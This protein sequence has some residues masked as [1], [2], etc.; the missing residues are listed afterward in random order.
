MQRYCPAT[1]HAPIPLSPGR[2]WCDA[3][4]GTGDHYRHDPQPDDPELH[5]RLHGV[6]CPVCAGAQ[7]VPRTCPRCGDDLGPDGRC[8]DECEVRHGGWERRLMTATTAAVLREARK[9]IETPE[10]WTKY[11]LARTKQGEHVDASSPDAVCFC[12]YGAI[13]RVAGSAISAQPALAVLDSVVDGGDFPTW[14]DQA[15]HAEALAAFDRAIAAEEE[16]AEC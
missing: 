6:P 8:S 10:R 1:R 12:G 13:Y 16:D 2:Q 11:A 15:D 7:T 14:Q 9:L 3:C 4:E 5:T